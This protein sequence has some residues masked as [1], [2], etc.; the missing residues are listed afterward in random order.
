MA[1]E[2]QWQDGA[3]ARSVWAWVGLATANDEW[4]LT[5][6]THLHLLWFWEPPRPVWIHIERGSLR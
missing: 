5:R 2:V 1:H 4:L 3:G 6:E